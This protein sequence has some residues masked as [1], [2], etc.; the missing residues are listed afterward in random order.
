MF[1]P[2]LD[3]KVRRKVLDKRTQYEVNMV[4]KNKENIPNPLSD[5]LEASNSL[6]FD[7]PSLSATAATIHTKICNIHKSGLYSVP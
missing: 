6:L 4:F 2:L 5:T 7:D 3:Q 1:E